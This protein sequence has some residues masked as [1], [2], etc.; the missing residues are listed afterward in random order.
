MNDETKVKVK[1]RI[2]SPVIYYVPDM[3][4]LRRE[5]QGRE[6]KVLTFEQLRKL[7]YVPGGQSILK[8]Y[9]IIKDKEAIEELNLNIE[10]EYFYEKEEVIELL[11]NGSMDEFLDCLD[12]AP[13]GVIDLIKECAI[14]LPL[15]D[16]SKREVLL[17][18]LNFDVT[19]II[20]IKKVTA[21]DKE[22]GNNT[23]S[24]RRVKTPSTSSSS[25]QTKGRRVVKISE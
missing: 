5:F 2:K 4:N 6:E 22:E 12:F 18:K 19:K 25:S 17:E 7:S 14:Q 13:N 9:L 11:K 21:E 3:G 1:N 23:T 24:K 10:P 8:N 20:E 15:N 16:V